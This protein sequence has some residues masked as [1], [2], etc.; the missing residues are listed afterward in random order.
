MVLATGDRVLGL[1]RG[2]EVT[3]RVSHHV[4]YIIVRS[5]FKVDSPRDQLGTLV[6]ELVEGVLAVGTGL[7]PDDGLPGVSSR[8]GNTSSE[9]LSHRQLT[10]VS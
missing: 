9:E 8:S 3:V 4:L 10:P 5:G 7:S 1:G 6:D 2:E